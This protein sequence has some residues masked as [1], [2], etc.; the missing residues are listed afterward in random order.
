MAS[1]KDRVKADLDRWIG[2]DLV[3]ADKRA[4]ILATLPDARRLDA[5]TAL[6]WVGGVLL[7][8]AVISFVAANWDVIPRLAR[9][10]LI[11]AAFAAFAGA[12]GWFG[13]RGRAIVSNILL[14]IA[15]LIF[16]SSIGLTGQIFDIAGD[17]RAASYGAAIAAFALAIAGRSTGAATVGLVFTALGDFAAG[18]WFASSESEAPWMLVAAPLGAFLALRWGS[19]ALAHV[20]ALAIIYCFA[21]FGGR[22]EA[23]A[24]TFLFLSILMGAM[25]AGARWLFNQ[26]RPFSGI[27]YGWFAAG[28]SLFFA[29]TGYLPWFGAEGSA[30]AGYAHRIVWLIASGGLLAL[31]RFDRHALVTT[32][33]VLGLIF[34]IVALLADLGLDLLASAGVFLLCA[35]IALVAGLALRRK[36]KTA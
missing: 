32:V 8:I 22:S 4:A 35:I 30:S 27:F 21:W 12:G 18:D 9:F 13:E 23:E 17:P 14:T 6:A 33:G 25:A 2:A 28:A 26:E 3:S 10:S 36:D 19:S 11:I 20:S 34:A 1:Y 7:G 24:S 31:G 15:A 5:A 29:V 16:A